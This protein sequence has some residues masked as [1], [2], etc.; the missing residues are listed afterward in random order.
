[1]LSK[2]FIEQFWN[3]LIKLNNKNK[4]EYNIIKH[5]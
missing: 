2:R 5:A 1:M 4:T 3:L